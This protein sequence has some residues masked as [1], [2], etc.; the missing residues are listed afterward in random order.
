MGPEG[1]APGCQEDGVVGFGGAC[2]GRR[3]VVGREEG[4]EVR[5]C[6]RRDVVWVEVGEVWDRVG[7]RG[8]RGSGWGGWLRGR[9]GCF[10]GLL[11][12]AVVEL[13]EIIFFIAFFEVVE[14]IAEVV[15]SLLIFCTV[16]ADTWARR[17]SLH[18]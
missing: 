15:F 12:V 5:F 8:L 1:G 3:R 4:V 6:Y 17:R 11:E 18:R 2:E 13:A 16:S 10:L 14:V 9:R 7:E